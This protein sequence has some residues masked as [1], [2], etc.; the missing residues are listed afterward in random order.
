M[1]KK[2]KYSLIKYIKGKPYKITG[3]G[4]IDEENLYTKNKTY[5]DCIR[6]CNKIINTDN[7]Y[8]GSF[9]QYEEI[10]VGNTLR[11]PFSQEEIK[12]YKST[13]EL[14]VSYFLWFMILN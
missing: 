9:T 2:V 13:I 7:Q 4:K 6:Y 5:E 1:N 10:K 11:N 14:E 8:K 12:R 3:Y